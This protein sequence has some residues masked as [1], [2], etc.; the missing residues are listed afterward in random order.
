MEEPTEWC[1]PMVVVP[2]PS[3]RICVDFT[4]LNEAVQ[5]ERHMLPSVEP[6]LGQ[7]AGACIFS[8]ID[9]NSGFHQI[10]LD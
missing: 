9:T 7:L 1:A 4:K 8:K 6:I 2:K 5:R 10:P 3:G